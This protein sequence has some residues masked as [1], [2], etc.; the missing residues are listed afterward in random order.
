MHVLAVLSVFIV[1][2]CVYK[3]VKHMCVQVCEPVYAIARVSAVVSSII[4]HMVFWDK[5]EPGGRLVA[6]NYHQFSCLYVFT[7]PMP[8]FQVCVPPCPV[9]YMGS[10]DLNSNP[11]ACPGS[12]LTTEPSP[13]F[14]GTFSLFNKNLIIMSYSWNYIISS[15]R[16]FYVTGISICFN[17]QDIFVI[18]NLYDL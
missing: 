17:N 4:F 3:N 5:V 9:Y 18:F 15:L 1:L 2:I 16:K 12:I 6:I 14:P 13:Q 10:G 8:V 11:S 7:Y